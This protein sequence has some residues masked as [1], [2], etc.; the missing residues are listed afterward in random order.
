VHYKLDLGIDHVLIDEAQ[1]TSPRQWDIVRRLVSEFT[2]GA[3]ARGVKRTIFAVGDEKQSIYSFQGADPSAFAEMRQQFKRT[4]EAAERDFRPVQF[5]L[6]FRSGPNVLGAVNAVFRDPTLAASLTDDEIGMPEH[7][8]LPDA[9]PGLVEIWDPVEPEDRPE[10][11][12]WERPYDAYDETSPKVVLARR[13]A[14]RIRRWIE[15][16]E[17]TSAGAPV[18]PGDILVLVR[19]RGPLFNAVIRALKDAEIPVAGADRLVLAEHIAVMDLLVLADAL[20]SPHDDLALATVLKSP[21]FGMS[22]EQLLQLAWARTGTLREALRASPDH[23]ELAARLDRLALAARAETPF[24][25]YSA[26]LGAE[27]GRH[28]MLAR[29]GPEAN[30]ALDEFLALALDYESRASPSVQGFAAWMRAAASEIKR[31]MD[32]AR[33]EVRVMTVHGAKGLEAPIVFVADTITRPSGPRSPLLLPIPALHSPPG[34]PDRMVWPG[35]KSRDCMVVAQARQTAEKKA[36]DEYRRLLYVAMTRAADRLVVCGAL[37]KTAKPAGC[38]YDL[39]RDSLA[40]EAETHQDEDGAV[41][42]WR[43]IK[44]AAAGAA[45]HDR[46]RP[47][48]PATPPSWLTQPVAA[49]GR[50]RPTHLAPSKATDHGARAAFS[51]GAARQFAMRRGRLIH[52]LMQCL[53]DVAPPER[54]AAARRYLD[55]AAGDLAEAERVSIT[56]EVLAVLADAQFAPLFAPGSRAEAPIVGQLPGLPD[57]VSGQV[58]RL[59][60]TATHVLIADYKTDRPAPRGADEVPQDYLVQLALYRGV[61]RQLYPDRDVRTALVWTDGPRLMRIASSALEE[62]LRRAQPGLP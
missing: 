41:L 43:K 52:R 48:A 28:R 9:A 37:G 23:A 24:S 58:D 50:R 19:Q 40:G 16:G 42:R 18:R 35:A 14:R 20:L 32:I 6:S 45:T 17:R 61:L 25:F 29:L 31:D 55:R 39:V 13:I 60:V 2:A 56:S 46:E 3:G 34:T 59:A 47:S 38:W 33:D 22:E 12:A 5:K 62:A 15:R 57:R 26:L 10:V 53:P 36:E 49:G 44:D 51:G 8:S 4:H 11:K 30:D 27:R 21:L 54:E 7:Q 1:D